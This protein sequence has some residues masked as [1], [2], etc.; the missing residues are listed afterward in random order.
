VSTLLIHSARQLLT[1][2]GGP[3]PRRGPELNQLQIIGDG[4]VL[5]EDGIIREV[6]PTRRLENLNAAR[7]AREISAAGRVV[8]PGL[9]DCHTHLIS[10][11]SLLSEGGGS[12]PPHAPI[13]ART[14]LA[15]VPYVREATSKRLMAEAVNALRRCLSHGTTTIEAKSGYGLNA[16]T[17]LK[18]LRVLTALGDAPITIVP[19]FSAA[20]VVPPE[21]EDRAGDYLEWLRSDLLPA[22]HK[23]GLTRFVHASCDLGAFSAAQLRPFLDSAHALGLPL[24]LS[25]SRYGPADGAELFRDHSFTSADHLDYLNEDGIVCLAESGTIAVLT[26]AATFFLG[27]RQHAPA[28]ALIDRGVPIAL[29]TNYSRVTCPTYN[30][31]LVIFLAC[32]LGGLKVA[33][34][35]T[36]ATINSAHALKLGH[37]AGSIEVGK[38][39]DLLIL[40]VGDYRELAHEFG[41]NLVDVTI[42]QGA[43][44]YERSGVKWPV[45][46]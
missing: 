27:G 13:D 2:R 4:A 26:P 11:P 37:R 42:K 31:Q 22:V 38:Q 18:I 16:S 32:H 35:V 20:Q 28:R 25:L 45:R 21:F 33:E 6:G 44:V 8:M 10:G 40:S 41:V 24:K 15:N 14:M 5:I 17:E 29:A 12:L 7:K 3:G 9:V 46:S 19:T 39:A 36:A 23:R 43:V 1:L 34:A 30:M